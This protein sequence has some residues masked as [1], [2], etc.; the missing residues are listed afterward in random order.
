MIQFFN[1]FGAINIIESII[2]LL[3]YTAF[4][5]LAFKG[6]QALNIYINKNGR[7]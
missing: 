7:G 3:A 5:C 6:V 4:I 1:F 2:R